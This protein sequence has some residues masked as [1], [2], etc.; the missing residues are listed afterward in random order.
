MNK[1]AITTN[2]ACIS[3]EEARKYGITI[4]PFHI[5]MDG[6]EHLDPE[7]DT[8][9]LYARLREKENLPTSATPTVTEF[10][11]AWQ[12]LSQNAEAILHISMTQAFTG[13]YNLALQAKEAAREKL[14]QTTIEVINS[15]TT[16]PGLQTH[17]PRGG[18]SG[19]TG[20]EPQGDNGTG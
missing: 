4:I 8:E 12:E 7:V 3:A 20:Q 1:V 19:S 6:K 9:N 14:P 15:R 16:G 5:I 18:R 2:S 13:A 10:L 17:Y 11:Q